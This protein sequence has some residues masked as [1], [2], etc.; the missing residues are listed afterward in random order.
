MRVDKARNI[1]ITSRFAQTNK[2]QPS[3]FFNDWANDKEIKDSKGRSQTLYHGTTHT[4]DQFD[5]NN[6]FGHSQGYHGKG[7]YFT[8]NSNDASSNYATVDGSDL[9]ERIQ[10]R[11]NQLIEMA[12]DDPDNFSYAYP[13]YDI[14]ED[15]DT[16]N[17]GND[18]DGALS[19]D[20]SKIEAATDAIAR[21]EIIGPHEGAIIPTYVRMQNPMIL[22]PGGGTNYQYDGEDGGDIDEDGNFKYTNQT[23]TAKMLHDAIMEVGQRYN[24]NM[25]PLWDELDEEF[26]FYDGVNAW[27]ID[28]AIRNSNVL[29]DLLDNPDIYDETENRPIPTFISQVY[30]QMGYDGIDMD[31]W[32]AFGPRGHGGMDGVTQSTRHYVTWTPENIKSAIGNNGLYDPKNPKITAR[33]KS[34]NGRVANDSLNS[35][36][37]KLLYHGTQSKNNFEIPKVQHSIGVHLGTPEQAKYMAGNVGRIFPLRANIQNPLR[38]HDFENDW[39]ELTPYLMY[40][41]HEGHI[42]RDEGKRKKDELWD[43]MM[44][45]EIQA[46]PEKEFNGAQA[47]WI[48]D[49]IKQFGYDGLVYGNN[50]EGDGD[51]YVAFDSHQLQHAEP[52]NKIAS[53]IPTLIRVAASLDKTS[54]YL[55]DQVDNLLFRLAYDYDDEDEDNDEI[56]D[57]D[58]YWFDGGTATYANGDIGDFNHEALALQAMVQQAGIENIPGL[59]NRHLQEGIIDWDE[60]SYHFDNMAQSLLGKEDSF[61]IGQEDEPEDAPY[62]RGELPVDEYGDQFADYVRNLYRQYGEDWIYQVDLADFLESYY[63][64][65]HKGS[66]TPEEIERAKESFQHLIKGMSDP[67][68]YVKKHMGWQRVAG[69]NIELYELNEKSARDLAKGL[70]D[71]FNYPIKQSFNI[72]VDHPVNHI[73]YGVPYGDIESGAVIRR[74]YMEIAPLLRQQS[75]QNVPVVNA[76]SQVISPVQQTATPSQEQGQLR[77]PLFQS[78]PLPVAHMPQTALYDPTEKAKSVRDQMHG[79]PGY[80]SQI[81]DENFNDIPRKQDGTPVYKYV[82][83]SNNLTINRDLNAAL[84][85]LRLGTQSLASA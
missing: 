16:D 15:I 72:E 33:V 55:A 78:E 25:Q 1:M 8:N 81:Y 35:V 74:Y 43:H 59:D 7:F 61:L 39:E 82:G 10:T 73:L 85:I 21:K 11:K 52:Q 2:K 37:D 64:T 4:F 77:L 47:K 84:N 69:R 66:G 68:A 46:L 6:P 41:E 45:D 32:A 67:R 49:Y 63:I 48:R 57:S 38:V 36:N 26:N 12:Q 62:Y 17:P 9:R 53:I 5:P 34:I 51:S 13:D 18:G 29:M 22:T 60:A 24:I 31:A 50:W 27:T 79:V 65:S 58:E 19:I 23:G 71:A 42:T 14:Y 44:S 56:S 20:Y 28:K 75:P 83:G 80:K 54:P 76:P 3:L 40:L 30:Q 70:D